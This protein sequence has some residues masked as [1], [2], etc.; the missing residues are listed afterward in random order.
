MC[1]SKAEPYG[2]CAVTHL[3]PLLSLCDACFSTPRNKDS[4][5]KGHG[6]PVEEERINGGQ[7]HERPKTIVVKNYFFNSQQLNANGSLDKVMNYFFKIDA[8]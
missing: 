4:C 2:T 6:T 3:R 7:H 5:H 1:A 8:E